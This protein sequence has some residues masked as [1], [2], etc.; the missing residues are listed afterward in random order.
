MYIYNEPHA[1]YNSIIL[2]HLNFKNF[3]SFKLQTI[4][5]TKFFSCLFFPTIYTITTNIH[6]Y[7]IKERKTI[8][9]KVTLIIT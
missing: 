1:L 9:K 7:D 8:I 6:N 2:I 3:H 5:R 4:K